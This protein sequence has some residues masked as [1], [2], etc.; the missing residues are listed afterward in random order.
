M[1]H[2]MLIVHHF[3]PLNVQVLEK[4]FLRKSCSISEKLTQ[5]Y[6]NKHQ[7]CSHNIYMSR[8]RSIV[9]HFLPL[10]VQVLEKKFLRK[11]CSISEN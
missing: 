11:S 4:S 8:Q 7:F 1:S 5:N 10:N 9:H 6:F 3:F 2:Q